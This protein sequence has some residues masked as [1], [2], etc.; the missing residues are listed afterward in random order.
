MADKDKDKNKEQE[1]AVPLSPEER[2]AKL[3]KGRR[4]SWII[5]GVL[6]LFIIIEGAALAFFANR[7]ADP[8]VAEGLQ[9]LEA[10]ETQTTS[11]QAAYDTAQTFN[12]NALQLEEKLD[13]IMTTI[14]LNNFSTLRKLMIEQEASYQQYL[15][16]L[17]QG[18]YDL[19]KMLKGSR[20]WY[21]VYR[22]DLDLVIG[23]SQVRAE[24]L[25]KGLVTPLKPKSLVEEQ[26]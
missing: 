25:K 16:A 1:E 10:L 20:T 11:M 13:R 2:I 17:Q 23:D 19:S 5:L 9:R 15:A 24:R 26:P 6:L 8:R 14:Q 21:E 12:D 3:E 22:D 7:D 4:T 18:M